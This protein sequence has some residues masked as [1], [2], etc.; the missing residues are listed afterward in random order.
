MKKHNFNFANVSISKTVPEKIQAIISTF[1]NINNEIKSNITIPEEIKSIIDKNDVSLFHN[2]IYY[3]FVYLKESN[4]NIEKAVSKALSTIP[5]NISDIVI[6]TDLVN[7]KKF[8]SIILTSSCNKWTAK[9]EE[10]KLISRNIVIVQNT[11]EDLTQQL[12]KGVA[13]AE[14]MSQKIRLIEMPSNYLTPKKLLAEAT[15]ILKNKNVEISHIVGKELEKEGYG[16]L[17]AV[18]KGSRNEGYLITIKYNG[19][20]KD[21][22]PIIL[23]GKGL[24]F[25]SGGISIKPSK[26]MGRMKGDMGG[27]ATVI[28][29]ILYA[30]NTGAKKNI[31]GIIATCENMPDGDALKPG[32]VITA[33]NGKTI[34]VEDTDAE[35]RLVLA[36]ALCLAQTFNGSMTVDFATLTGAVISAIGYVHTGLF[37]ENDS[38]SNLFEKVGKD[39]GD[40]V[41]RLP[42]SD[43]YSYFLE[44][45][46]ADMNNL[47]LGQGAGAT[48]GAIFLREF[49]PKENWVHLDIAGTSDHNGATGRPVSLISELLD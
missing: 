49:A 46:V 32:D 11:D 18:S 36:D 47:C 20:D 5:K 38:L 14:A 48:N 33:K 2:G 30:I 34:E 12:R 13:L 25:D 42:L 7:I 35:G 39:S 9:T 3:S 8:V 40:T 45:S 6:S 4:K 26:G 22:Q 37:T 16:S 29:S 28:S 23:V 31:V 43:D 27:A 19:A 17:Y 15:S 21:E 1:T 44:S 41:W 24:T 10:N